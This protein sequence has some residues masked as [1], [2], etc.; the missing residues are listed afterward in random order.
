[1]A[2]NP[3]QVLTGNF[4]PPI[5][6]TSQQLS[7]LTCSDNMY[8][9]ICEM[10]DSS[11]ISQPFPT[12]QEAVN[13]G[14]SVWHRMKR[15]NVQKVQVVDSTCGHAD[16]L[17]RCPTPANE[18]QP[19]YYAVDGKRYHLDRPTE[20]KWSGWT[21]LTTGSDYHNRKTIAS[22]APDGRVSRDHSVLQEIQKDPFARAA[23]YGQI[24]GSCAACG[25][26]LEDPTSRQ[27][28]MGPVCRQKWG[29]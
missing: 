8:K 12:K 9:L 5:M 4:G 19:G 17:W 14:R 7:T 1:M 29:I 26:K 21:F 2:E 20:G 23:E 22:A 28:G 15:C 16:I 13:F 25:R 10:K 18:L 11:R 6:G 24:T 3:L 27:I